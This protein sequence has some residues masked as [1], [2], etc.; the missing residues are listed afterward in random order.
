MHIIFTPWRYQYVKNSDDDEDCVFCRILNAGDD[1]EN[2]VLL[3]TELNFVVLNR[4]PYTSGHLMIAPVR[5]MS[6][7][8]KAR[9][10]ELNE[11]MTLCSESIQILRKVFKPEGFNMGMNIGRVAGAGAFVILPRSFCC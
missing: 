8:T 1:A 2:L 9:P 4:Y 7:V 11:L 5:H 3:R 10:E 6:E